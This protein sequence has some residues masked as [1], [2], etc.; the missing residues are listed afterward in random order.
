MTVVSQGEDLVFKQADAD[1]E[2]EQIH[3]L[4]YQ[5]FAKEIAQHA[6]DGSG[7]L[8]DRLHERSNYFIARRGDRV[9]GM[10]SVH[11]DPPFS[12]ESRLS[13]PDILEALG[14]RLLEVRLLAID[15]EARHSMVFGELLW[16]L[17]CYARDR[18]YSHLIISG[19]VERAKLY[20]RMGFR[21]LGPPVANGSAFFVPMALPLSRPAASDLGRHTHI[22]ARRFEKQ[23]LHRRLSLMPGPVEIAEPVRQAFCRRP[24]SHRGAEFI[25]AH[26]RVRAGLR[27]LAAGMEV[28]LMPG[29]GTAANDA[30]A[31]QL[32][33]SFGDRAGLVLVNGE[34]GERLAGQASRAGLR[35]R[36]LDWPWGEAWD[37]GAIAAALG[38]GAAWAWGVHLETSAGVLNAAG[39]FVRAAEECG[40]RVA[41]DCISSIGAVPLPRGVWMATGVSGKALGS[42]AGLAFVLCRCE[43]LCAGGE[44]PASLDIAAS[45]RQVG[46]RYTV[47]SPLIFA[48]DR[49][50]ALYHGSEQLSAMRFAQAEAVGRYVRVRLGEVG[51]QPVA[52]ECVAAP[53]VTAFAADAERFVPACER[54]GYEVAGHTGYLRDRGWVQIATMGAVTAADLD[55]LW[56]AIQG[57]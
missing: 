9:V 35:F 30:V 31:L 48:L 42:Y 41:L 32:R 24:V 12:I 13:S 27:R 18:D 47:A 21:R 49:A 2:F 19:I 34:F 17:F 37:V 43:E 11:D 10:V 45:L 8:I 36:R 46:S 51:L 1:W 7:I 50:L 39:E 23:G 38:E 57:L 4:N 3:Q 44:V 55:E 28:A 16:N 15:P 53:S 25:E 26:E 56:P 14:T 52:K 33:A 22:F 20:E 6:A 54:A 40:V 29:S 5:V